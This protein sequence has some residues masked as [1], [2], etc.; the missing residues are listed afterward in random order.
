MSWFSDAL[1]CPQ[2]GA[3]LEKDGDE[4]VCVEGTTPRY[5]YPILDGVPILLAD[6][7]REVGQ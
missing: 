4:L 2:T 7:A 1:R 3:I 6:Q 5:A